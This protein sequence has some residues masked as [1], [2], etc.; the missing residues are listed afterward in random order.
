MIKCGIYFD[1]WLELQDLQDFIERLQL[2]NT[3]EIFKLRFIQDKNRRAFGYYLIQKCI[4]DLSG[5]L[6]GKW[7]S[8]GTGK[9]VYD[10]ISFNVSHD[11]KY[12][13]IVAELGNFLLGV[14]VCWM[15]LDFELQEF[16]DYLTEKEMEWIDSLKCS[17]IGFY[18]IWALKEATT[19]GIGDGMAFGF[20]R[21][22]FM[23][24]FQDDF[25]LREYGL[26][27]VLESMEFMEIMAF[28]DNKRLDWKFS[29][30]FLDMEHVVAIASNQEF[31]KTCFNIRNS[32]QVLK[33]LS[34]G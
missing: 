21:L 23:I 10:G 14:D 31:P 3:L 2:Q 5:N 29:I 24:S 1:N 11:Y 13:V 15:N 8:S 9:P 17:K 32:S 16:T 6:V 26:K 18:M 34:K 12:V 28:L 22:E 25:S 19:K 30:Q 20:K 4:Q 7:N 27:Q 33:D